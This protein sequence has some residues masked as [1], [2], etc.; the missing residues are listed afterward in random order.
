MVT[1]ATLVGAGVGAIVPEYLRRRVKRHNLR[2]ALKTEIDE[3]HMLTTLEPDILPEPALNDII[4]TI[5]YEENADSIGLLTHDEVTKIVRFYSALFWFQQELKI[6]EASGSDKQAFAQRNL[7]TI[8][9][10]RKDALG[11]IKRNL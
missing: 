6:F 8:K 11:A 1:V 9:S 2:L 4:P 5:I 10:L 3:M 7:D